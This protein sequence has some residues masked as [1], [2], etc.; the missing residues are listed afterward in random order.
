MD[1]ENNILKGIMY[2]TMG[3]LGPE[4][5]FDYPEKYF[6]LYKLNIIPIK[7]TTVLTGEEG[8]VPEKLSIIPFTKYEILAIVHYFEVENSSS[9]G[10]VIDSNITVLFNEKYSSIIYKYS[11]QFEPLLKELAKKINQCEQINN[12]L[13]IRNLLEEMYS[14]LLKNLA[15]LRDAEKKAINRIRDEKPHYRAKVVVIGDAGVGKTT[16]LLKY[17][18]EAFQE[19]YLPTIGVNLSNKDVW[20]RDKKIRLNIYDIA[21]QERFQLTRRIFYEGLE[22]VLIVFDVTNNDSFIHVDNWI[23]DVSSAIYPQKLK[24]L[25]IG[26][27]ID[28]KDTRKITKQAADDVAKKYN[29]ASMEISAKTGEN[30]NETFK[31]LA[32]KLIKN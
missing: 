24:G 27:K 7:T 29:L 32:E 5:K 18:D 4:C 11:E 9:R 23:K 21:G 22:A 2:N 6:D 25:L 10:G 16:M 26:N 12:Q 28:L 17:V 1:S 19:S 30:I 14:T 31:K 13:K 15:S 20:V 8:R 3:D